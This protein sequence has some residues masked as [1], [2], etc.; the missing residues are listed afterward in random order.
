MPYSTNDFT[1]FIA[2]TTAVKFGQF[3]LKSGKKSPIFFDFGQLMYGKEL[4]ELGRFFADFIIQNSLQDTDVLFGPAYKGINII[5]ATSIA[6]Y[7]KY[8][9]SIPFAYNRKIAKDYA[10]GGGFVGFDLSAAKTVLILDDVFTDGGTKYEAIKMLSCFK[11]LIIRAIIVG[12][13]RQEVDDFGRTYISTFKQKTQIDVFALTTK[14][15][16]LAIRSD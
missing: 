2:N 11:Q 12:V 1:R 14:D 8:G 5:I 4:I 6:L 9:L 16:V 3:T 15:K 13:D 10:E 7:E